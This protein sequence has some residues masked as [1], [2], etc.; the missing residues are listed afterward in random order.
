MTESLFAG[1]P[2][3]VCVERLHAAG[4]VVLGPENA[5]EAARLLGM[6]AFP[7]WEQIPALEEEPVRDSA[8]ALLAAFPARDDGC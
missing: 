3:H 5:E 2:L 4:Y 1:L 8:V 6:I 7:F